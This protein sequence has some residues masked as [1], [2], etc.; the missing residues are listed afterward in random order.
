MTPDKLNIGKLVRELEKESYLLECFG[1]NSECKIN[2]VCKLKA[3]LKQAEN[4]FFETLEDYTLADLV[5]NQRQ[6]S[7][8]LFS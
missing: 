5:I 3:A 8:I 1:K 6:L 4:N 7:S 2:P